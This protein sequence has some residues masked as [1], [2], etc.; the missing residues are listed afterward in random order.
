[1][2]LDMVQV[3]NLYFP[4]HRIVDFE[5]VPPAPIA[6]VE[7]S[8]PRHLR[9]PA[10]LNNN[11]LN[12]R[13]LP[14]GQRWNGQV[15][16]STYAAS[17]SFCKFAAPEDGVS[18]AVQNLRSYVLQGVHTMH[19]VI[20]RWAPPNDPHM[21]NHTQAYLDSV[22]RYA[23]IEAGYSIAWIA[24]SAADDDDRDTLVRII[25]GMNL[26]EAGGATVTDDQVRAGIQKRLGVPAGYVRGEDGNVK[27]ADIKQSGTIRDANA[28][29]KANWF[30]TAVSSAGIGGAATLMT[31]LQGFD[32]RLIGIFAVVLTIVVIAGVRTDWKFR[33]VKKR[34]R[35]MHAA[36]IA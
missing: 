28:G 19:D 34:R 30:Q 1:M 7:P 13:P 18:A 33:S 31:S 12:I 14:G 4:V 26:V 2:P 27:R 17:G 16:V 23:G 5:A 21:A 25:R 32:W 11:P 8:T 10:A 36:E 15:G 20:Y 3:D 22:C 29:Q 35:Q 9:T 6:L 24:T